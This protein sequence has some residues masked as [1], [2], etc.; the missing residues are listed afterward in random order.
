MN[1]T[2]FN[3]LPGGKVRPAAI[4]HYFKI[5]ETIAHDTSFGRAKRAVLDG[6]IAADSGGNS[7]FKNLMFRRDEPRF[8]AFDLLSCNVTYRSANAS[9]GF[10]GWFHSTASAYSIATTSRARANACSSV[11]VNVTWRVSS[12]NRSSIHPC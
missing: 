2:H 1:Q 8:D 12:P 7:Q 4:T 5:H 11:R 6:E 9:T 10:E 3:L